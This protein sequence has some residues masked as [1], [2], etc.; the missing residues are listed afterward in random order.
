M[1]SAI[2]MHMDTS[3]TVNLGMLLVAFLLLPS[4]VVMASV[5]LSTVLESLVVTEAVVGIV[6]NDEGDVLP[7]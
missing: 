4:H 7:S 1:H 2:T 3:N 5:L 6:G